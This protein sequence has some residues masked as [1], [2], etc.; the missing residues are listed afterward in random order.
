MWEKEGALSTNYLADLIL[1]K[2]A[3]LKAHRFLRADA[4]REASTGLLPLILCHSS[5]ASERE[6][7]EAPSASPPLGKL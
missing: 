3:K 2:G 6:S 4:T 5:V 7:C 1:E